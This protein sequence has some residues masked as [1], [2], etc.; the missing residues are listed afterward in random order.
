MLIEEPVRVNPLHRNLS[1]AWLRMKRPFLLK[2]VRRHTLESIDGVPVL[3]LPEVLNPVVFRSGEFLARTLAQAAA[4]GG[5][6]RIAL[7]MGT[8]SGVG[9][10]F[11][12]R[13]G[14]RVVAVDV[15]PEAVRCARINAQM[16]RLEHLIE[17]REGDLFAP[18]AGQRFD[19]VLFN[20]PFF[21]G[22]P[23]DLFD[24]AWR[25]DHVRDRFAAA[26]PAALT[27]QGKALILLSTDGEAA[28]MLQALRRAGLQ[29][30]AVAQRNYGNEIM[31]V[32][33]ARQ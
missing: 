17:V 31:T 13:L 29:V 21:R 33:Q 9:A 15:N 25:D 32:Y 10:L 18:V 1:L 12:A 22:K 28:E 26:L 8:G 23:K 24:L 11:A 14:Y 7:D 3:V 2:R 4:T 5:E 19:L 6:P 16:N 27:P 20:P 30:E